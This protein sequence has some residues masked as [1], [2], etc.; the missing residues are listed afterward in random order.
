VKLLIT[1]QEVVDVRA[2]DGLVE[3]PMTEEEIENFRDSFQDDML[4]AQGSE[5][6]TDDNKFR[7]TPLEISGFSVEVIEDAEEQEAENGAVGD[8]RETEPSAAT[9]SDGSGGESPAKGDE[10]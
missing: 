4:N 7:Y 2:D 1:R 8:D 6:E 9:A 5:H 3:D 10:S